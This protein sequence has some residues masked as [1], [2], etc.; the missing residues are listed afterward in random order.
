VS[1]LVLSA[2]IRVHL[3]FAF[4][5]P[6]AAN[7]KPQIHA[8]QERIDTDIFIISLSYPVLSAD[9][10]VHQRFVFHQ[11]QILNCRWTKIHTLLLK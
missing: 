4:P 10:R 11:Q 1:N 2:A 9:I 8:D 6:S 5:R 7:P 3:R